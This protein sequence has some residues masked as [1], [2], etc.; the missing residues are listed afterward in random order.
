M[1]FYFLGYI[2]FV[3]VFVSSS[4]QQFISSFLYIDNEYDDDYGDEDEDEDDHHVTI[5]LVVGFYAS[6]DGSSVGKKFLHRKGQKT[7]KPQRIN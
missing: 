1:I 3:Y 7:K 6:N 4:Q 2:Y 5:L